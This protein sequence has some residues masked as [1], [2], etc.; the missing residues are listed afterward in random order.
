[1]GGG[2]EKWESF[3]GRNGLDLVDPRGGG[4]PGCRRRAL[5]G[6]GRRVS[7]PPPRKGSNTSHRLRQVPELLE[8]PFNHFQKFKARSDSSNR[9]TILSPASRVVKAR[10]IF[11]S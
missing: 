8:T 1:M 9:V 2:G 3:L 4:V 5:P 10:S 11:K 6:E 7:R